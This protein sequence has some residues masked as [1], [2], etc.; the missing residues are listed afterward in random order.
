MERNLRVEQH[1]GQEVGVLERPDH[2][3][4]PFDVTCGQD[5]V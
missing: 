2:E 5:K 1:T 3:E 4:I